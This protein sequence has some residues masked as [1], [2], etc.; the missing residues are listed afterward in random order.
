[1]DNPDIQAALDKNSDQFL[2]IVPI[3]EL[4]TR[5]KMK[6]ILSTRQVT[7]IKALTHT[8]DMNGRLLEILMEERTEEDFYTFCDLLKSNGVN[9]VKSFGAKLQDDAKGTPIKLVRKDHRTNPNGQDV[10]DSP[11]EVESTLSANVKG[12]F[13]TVADKIGND[14]TRLAGKLN[15]NIDVGVIAE[16]QSVVFNRAKAVLSK[17]YNMSGNEATT[18]ALVKVLIAIERKDIVKDFVSVK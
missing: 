6:K 8:E 18:E 10:V 4:F 17:W 7:D 1:M 14:W 2:K 15:E 5:L 9:V 3:Q 12:Y 11:M 13:Y 16:E